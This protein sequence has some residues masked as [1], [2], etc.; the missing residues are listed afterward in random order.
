V[1]LIQ[2]QEHEAC[3]TR[4]VTLDMEPLPESQTKC[5]QLLVAAVLLIGLE[6]WAQGVQGVH[7]HQNTF[8]SE[9][10]WGALL[11]NVELCGPAQ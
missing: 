5:P 9:W 3:E 11:V 6:E 2:L 1:H 4:G 8:G 7:L 10:T